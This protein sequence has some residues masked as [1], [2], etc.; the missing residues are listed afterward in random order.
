MAQIPMGCSQKI[1]VN[2]QQAQKRNKKETDAE[3]QT[4]AKPRK[5]SKG[6]KETLILEAHTIALEC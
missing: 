5:L 2:Q 6:R 1:Q 3:T 4:S